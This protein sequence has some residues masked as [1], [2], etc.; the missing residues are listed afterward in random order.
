MAVRGFL[1]GAFFFFAFSFFYG[2]GYFC[3]VKQQNLMQPALQTR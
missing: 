3:R 2:Y 1:Q